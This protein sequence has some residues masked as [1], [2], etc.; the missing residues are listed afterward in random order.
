MFVSIPE[1]SCAEG[2]F[3]LEFNVLCL[4]KGSRDILVQLGYELVQPDNTRLRVEKE[5]DRTLVA[6]VTADILL[7]KAELDKYNQRIHPQQQQFSQYLQ[8]LC[9]TA[10]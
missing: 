1:A 8:H 7:L 5:P 2:S 9:H 3:L 10:T 6:R 4:L